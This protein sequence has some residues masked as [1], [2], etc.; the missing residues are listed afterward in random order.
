M[1]RVLIFLI[2][3]LLSIDNV[4]AVPQW[5]FDVIGINDKVMHYTNKNSPVAVTVVDSGVA[6]V[7]GL[8]DAEFAKYSYTK[9]GSPYPVKGDEALYIHGTAM[10]SI[11]AS[12]YGILGVYQDAMIS[13]RRVIPN[14]VTDSWIKAIEA[15]SL[16]NN[17]SPGQEKIINVSG[18]QKGSHS[19]TA[20]TDLLSRLG[21]END[22]LIVAAV[23]NDGADI[24]T[25]TPEQRIWPAAYHPSSKINKKFDPVIRVA[26]L[27]Q[28]TKSQ[29]PS[30]HSGGITGSRYG[31]GWVDIAAPG[32]NINYLKPDNTI[33]VGSGTSEATAIVSGVL[34][35]MSSCNPRATAQ[36]LKKTL[37]DTADQYSSLA[38]KVTDGRVLNA[39]K[40]IESFCK[41]NRVNILSSSGEL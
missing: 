24:R 18:G 2:L 5:Y 12:R 27:A 3:S 35:A 9:D 29:T 8:S 40:A 7:G 6:F 4:I 20:W 26:A 14:G 22:K 15:V 31:N 32:Q 30:L 10:A 34:A 11:I 25:I 21:K 28:Y 19:A 17:L 41:K 16:N 38:D 23:G 39:G 33:G 1:M 13:N 37:L 36:E